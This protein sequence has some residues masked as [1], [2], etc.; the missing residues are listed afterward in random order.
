MRWL[1]RPYTERATYSTLGYLFAGLPVAVVGFCLTAVGLAVGVGLIITLAGIPI[2]ITMFRLLHKW[3]AFEREFASTWLDITIPDRRRRAPRSSSM[4]WRGLAGEV[5]HASTW[6]EV[7]WVV[8]RLPLGIVGFVTAVVIVSLMFGG[9]AQPILHLAGVHNEI[10]S[11]QIDTLTE[12][13]AFVPV[14]VLFCVLGPRLI[15]G[16]GQTVG[17]VTRRFLGFIEPAELTAT[18]ERIVADGP[19][20]PFELYG[21]LERQLGVGPWLSKT[22]VEATLLELEASGRVNGVRDTHDV[23]YATTSRG[24]VR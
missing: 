19:I 5:R 1:L 9:F 18:I 21:L 12:S 14:S 23:T 20:G 6:R 16:A 15:L 3:V 24:S 10:G 17:A 22:R 13:V 7:A 8:V 11:W 4:W 2:L